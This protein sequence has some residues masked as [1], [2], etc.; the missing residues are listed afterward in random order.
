MRLE[1]QEHKIEGSGGFQI[2]ADADADRKRAEVALDVQP[3]TLDCFGMR[4]PR[5]HLDGDAASGKRGRH[6]S[7][8]GARADDGY[9]HGEAPARSSKGSGTNLEATGRFELPNGAFA[10]PCLTTWLRRRE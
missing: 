8:D 6:E 3:V 1:G 10:E 5:E 7:P 9:A 2:F 4:A